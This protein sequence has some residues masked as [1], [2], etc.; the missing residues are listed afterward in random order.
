[1]SNFIK[2]NSVIINKLR[3]SKIEIQD[4]KYC[5]HLINNSIDG[6]FL[7]TSGFINTLNDKIVVCKNKDPMDY[8]SMTEWI[9]QIK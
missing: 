2:L 8:N 1:M 6:F 7:F 3:I 9:N 5:I 4:N